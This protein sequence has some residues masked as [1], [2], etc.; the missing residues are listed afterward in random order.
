MTKANC[1]QQE[2]FIGWTF[3][4]KS[5]SEERLIKKVVAWQE[6]P[7]NTLNKI[8][9][10]PV[11]TLEVLDYMETKD[12]SKCPV[13]NGNGKRKAKKVYSSKGEFVKI[14]IKCKNC[15]HKTSAFKWKV[16]DD[17][18]YKKAVKRVIDEWNNGKMQEGEIK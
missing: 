14:K 1:R 13:C 5:V 15:G 11:Y 18:G 2:G 6:L 17:T 12:I 10:R 9:N 4:C 3:G 16:S 7:P 8:E